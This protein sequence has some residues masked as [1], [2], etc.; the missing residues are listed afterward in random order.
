VSFTPKNLGKFTQTVV[1][2]YCGGLYQHILKCYG[3]APVVGEKT[4]PVKGLEK[5]GKDFAPDNKYVNPESMTLG[6]PHKRNLQSLTKIMK[7]N[8][9]GRSDASQA[10]DL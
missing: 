10:L 1:I 5:T 3:H 9:W 7:S 2:E 4:A 8:L 6:M